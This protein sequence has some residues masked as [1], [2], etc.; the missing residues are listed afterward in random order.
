MSKPMEL[1]VRLDDGALAPDRAY[2]TDA[3]ADLF[4]PH[5]VHVP[6][7]GSALVDTG[8]HVELPEG[9]CGLLVSKSGLN[10][11]ENVLSTGLIDAGYTGSIA[12]KLYNHGEKPVTLGKGSKISQLVVL[13]VLLPRIVPVDEISGGPRGENGFG[14]TETAPRVAE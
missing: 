3:G 8:V 14:S 2:P 7:R 13:P 6:A 11:R 1:K 12:V 10:V 5:D 9:T 4:A